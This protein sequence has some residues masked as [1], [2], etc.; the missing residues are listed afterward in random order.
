MPSASSKTYR[1]THITRWRSGWRYKRSVPTDVRHVLGVASWSKYLGAVS[2]PDAIAEARKL[3]VNHDDL[4]RRARALSSDDHDAIASMGGLK[5]TRDETTALAKMLK[6]PVR[7]EAEVDLNAADALSQL[8]S[9]RVRRGLAAYGQRYVAETEQLLA[10]LKP[11]GQTSKLATLIPIWQRVA[12]PRQSKSIKKKHL[13]VARLVNVIGDLEPRAV[14]RE[15]AVKFREAMEK[16]GETR[17]N[18]KH[19]LEELHRL[20]SVALS[21]NL[22]DTNPFAGVKARKDASAK[23]SAEDGDKTFS[24]EQVRA[25]LS[26]A[27]TLT[28]VG[29]L[30]LQWIIR[31]LAYHGARS[32]EICQLRPSDITIAAGIQVLRITDEVGSLKNKFS[33]RDIP[34][35]PECRGIVA[36][37]A[38]RANE[39]WLFSQFSKAKDKAA[40]FQSWASSFLDKT[41]GI[42]DPDLTMHGLRHTWR[43]IAREIDMPEAVSRAI[44]GHSLGKGDHA[45]YG[46]VPSLAKR[47]AWMAKVDPLQA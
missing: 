29:A 5:S 32:G 42:T 36:Y 26:A 17:T 7:Q 25:I 18:T 46:T 2:E 9:I 44:M 20:F 39:S 47:A 13:Y 45:A 28:K 30:D 40:I 35:H 8:K 19:M 21:E 37:A 12:A 6:L 1:K 11:S 24:G 34:I 10:N 41:V 38:A 15:H 22:I 27:A 4:I 14:R 33:K 43:T 23:F 31:L 3:D 16:Q